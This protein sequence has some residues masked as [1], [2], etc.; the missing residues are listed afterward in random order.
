MRLRRSRWL[1]S[2]ESWLRV[3]FR[4]VVRGLLAFYLGVW[5]SARR[6]PRNAS[7]RGHWKVT[8]R[9]ERADKANNGNWAAGPHGFTQWLQHT[10]RGPKDAPWCSDAPP[11]RLAD[12]PKVERGGRHWNIFD[13]GPQV[14]ELYISHLKGP[15]GFER[16]LLY[17]GTKIARLGYKRDARAAQSSPNSKRWPTPRTF[18]SS[19]RTRRPGASN[20]SRFENFMEKL[21]PGQ[22][23]VEWPESHARAGTPGRKRRAARV[24]KELHIYAPQKRAATSLRLQLWNSP[25][26]TKSR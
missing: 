25:S 18:W 4:R 2:L 11:H 9:P 20:Y 23:F 10:R 13:R 5:R 12:V 19:F 26:K 21:E 17:V 15:K 16:L 3:R 8:G 24:P 1:C 22:K 14:L 7:A 6:S